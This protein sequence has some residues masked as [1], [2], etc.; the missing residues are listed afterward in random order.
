V[1]RS[2]LLWVELDPVYVGTAIRRWQVLTGG[3]ARCSPSGRLFDDLAGEAEAA[4][5]V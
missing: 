4:N 1:H 2:A 5:S 3:E